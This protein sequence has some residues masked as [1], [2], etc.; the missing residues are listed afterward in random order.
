MCVGLA[1][2]V[3]V[4]GEIVIIIELQREWKD[5]EGSERERRRFCFWI[6]DVWSGHGGGEETYG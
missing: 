6:R 3:I 2:Y 4:E 1:I 5:G